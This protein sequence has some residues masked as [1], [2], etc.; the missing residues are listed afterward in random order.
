MRR[1]VPGDVPGAVAARGG[2]P[3][4]QNAEWAIYW[5]EI[6]SPE[7]LSPSLIQKAMAL[8]LRLPSERAVEPRAPCWARGACPTDHRI[9]TL[10]PFFLPRTTALPR[11]ITD[12]STCLGCNSP[13]SI[14]GPTL[15][16]QSLSLQIPPATSPCHCGPRGTRLQPPCAQQD[17]QG[18]GCARS[19][20]TRPTPALWR[21][22][23]RRTL[24]Q[25]G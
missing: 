13:G 4:M 24:G 17:S 20:S 3:A 14:L 8:R 21:A 25:R 15:L 9:P 1:V 23:I 10:A 22:P 12:F 19:S 6:R 7:Q 5:K 2:A 18:K 16:L 11:R